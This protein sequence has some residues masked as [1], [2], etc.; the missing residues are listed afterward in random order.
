MKASSWN[1]KSIPHSSYGPLMFGL[2]SIRRWREV[3]SVFRHTFGGV[4][5]CRWIRGANFLTRRFAG[6]FFVHE[7]PG[8][9][10]SSWIYMIHQHWVQMCQFGLIMIFAIWNLGLK[11]E[12]FWQYRS[13]LLGL[14]T[15]PGCP[16]WKICNKSGDVNQ[17]NVGFLFHISIWVSCNVGS[18]DLELGK[19][20]IQYKANWRF[21][22][23][24][25]QFTLFFSQTRLYSAHVC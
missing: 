19:Y 11:Y 8:L 3:H 18:V 13:R 9:Q 4:G 15:P 7:N 14:L 10:N 22:Y 12:P 16:D 2:W 21:T 17:P 23:F 5:G 24:I 20:S 6:G 1:I 25:Y